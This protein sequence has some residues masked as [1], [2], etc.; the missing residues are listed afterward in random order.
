MVWI[1]GGR[2]LIASHDFYPEERPIHPV[3]VDG[4]WM[5]EHLVTN[6]AF[7]RFVS[8]TGHVT[9]AERCP[10]PADYP[11]ADPRLLVPG[12]PV[13]CRPPQRVSLDD[14]RAWWNYV[15]A[16][17]WKHPEGPGSTLQGRE[18]NPEVHIAYEDAEA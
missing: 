14:Y 3:T 9:V 1:P 10:N 2:F 12:S 15:L 13:F 4:F 8:A 6:A 11:G 7:R 17:C 18:H 5:D 16:A